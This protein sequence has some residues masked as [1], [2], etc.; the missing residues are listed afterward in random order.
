MSGQ[1][2]VGCGP[3]AVLLD[4]VGDRSRPSVGEDGVELLRAAVSVARSFGS[5]EEA[6]S[7][8]FGAVPAVKDPRDPEVLKM[9]DP[10]G[11]HG[12]GFPGVG[13]LVVGHTG[14]VAA[15]LDLS[16]P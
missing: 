15:W 8:F 3:E 13:Q 5:V 2:S 12:P 10:A 1:E 11:E 9:A 14:S 6:R 7:C 16:L 4:G